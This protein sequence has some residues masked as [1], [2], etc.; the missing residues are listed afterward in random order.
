MTKRAPTN[1]LT[2][3]HHWFAEAQRA[4]APLPEAMALATADMKGRPSVR[5]VL[6]KGADARGFV[7]YTN[8]R[9]RKGREL[10]R[11]QSA[12]AVFYWDVIGKQVRI[13]GTVEHVAAADADAYW[14]TRP[15]ESQLAARASHQSAPLASHAALL[16]LW[17]Q[18]RRTYRG[19][20]IPRPRGWV[21]IR[22]VP[23]TIEFWTRG[24]HRLHQR[25]LFTRNRRGW[26]R[27]LLQ[28]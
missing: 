6:L 21:G 12:S 19:K 27:T 25:E 18:L 7:F 9:S 20:E 24:E 3:F 8:G 22:I 5:F 10:R 26:K 17:K 4:G 11:N 16:A 1:P 2:Q 13:D 15:R 23:A 28:P 14:A